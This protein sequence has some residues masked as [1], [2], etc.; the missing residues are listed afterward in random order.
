MRILTLFLLTLLSAS[1]LARVE[2][3]QIDRQSVLRCSISYRDFNKLGFS[4]I[5]ATP[6]S[7]VRS[8]GSMT[9]D[10]GMRLSATQIEMTTGTGRFESSELYWKVEVVREVGR[11]LIWKGTVPFEG[12]DQNVQIKMD[13]NSSPMEMKAVCDRMV[14]AG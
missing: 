8:G 11:Q 6:Y 4:T 3:K 5:S 9:D 12:F 7:E 10:N 13:N 1:A 14:V 2:K